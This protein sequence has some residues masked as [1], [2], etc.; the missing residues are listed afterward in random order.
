MGDQIYPVRLRGIPD[1]NAQNR[2]RVGEMR[3]RSDSPA[4]TPSKA[5]GRRTLYKLDEQDASR[6]SAETLV[7]LREPCC[8]MVLPTKLPP[9]KE[10]VEQGAPR[11]SAGTL[12]EL[13]EASTASAQLEEAFRNMGLSEGL[14]KAAA[15]GR[16]WEPEN[17]P[18]QIAVK[19]S[20]EQG[21]DSP[22]VTRLEEAFRNMGLSENSAKV[23][24]R[25]RSW[26]PE[27]LPDQVTAKESVE[28]GDDSPVV[29]RLEEA[30]RNMG[31]SEN[32]AKVAARGHEGG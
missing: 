32:S 2:E 31:L 30:F 13:C 16:S 26:E 24:A 8:G 15:R 7:E 4:A 27:N 9:V 21:D 29:T 22:V 14:A 12:I 20:V 23:A 6:A 28:Q 3:L 10:S 11:A 19:E 1:G 17:L 18:D 5:K 25:G